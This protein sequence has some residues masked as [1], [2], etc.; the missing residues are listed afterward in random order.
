MTVPISEDFIWKGQVQKAL[1][2]NIHEG[3]TESNCSCP[4]KAYMK[5]KTNFSLFQSA[6]LHNHLDT[7]G[8]WSE[9]ALNTYLLNW[10]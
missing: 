1:S 3:K 10:I 7:W 2:I 4:Q 8:P 6:F 9:Q 5:Y